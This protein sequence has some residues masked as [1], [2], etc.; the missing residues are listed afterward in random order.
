MKIETGYE[1][2]EHELAKPVSMEGVISPSTLKKI[3]APQI[4]VKVL[5]QNADKL[6]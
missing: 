2:E 4:D 6:F 1:V 5:L 3:P